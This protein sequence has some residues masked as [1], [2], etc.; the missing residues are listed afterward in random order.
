M[1]RSYSASIACS[2]G[3]PAAVAPFL[4][5]EVWNGL[6]SLLPQS[7]GSSAKSLKAQGLPQ[8]DSVLT[9]IVKIYLAS[10]LLCYL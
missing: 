5:L 2:P 7:L 4:H 3:S 1:P 9:A 6:W 10:S 8:S